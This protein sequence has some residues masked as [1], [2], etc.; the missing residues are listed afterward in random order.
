MIEVKIQLF[1]HLTKYLQKRPNSD[2]WQI[3]VGLDLNGLLEHLS[4]PADEV[5]IISVNDTLVKDW[6][7][8]LQTGDSV[9][10]MAPVAGG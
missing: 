7:T 1:G 8:K 10:I 6:A 4:I 2:Q 9:R 5:W 3:P